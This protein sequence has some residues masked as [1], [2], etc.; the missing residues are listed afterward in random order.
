LEIKKLIF[1][2]SIIEK[3]FNYVL[4]IILLKFWYFIIY[5]ENLIIKINLDFQILLK[6]SIFA[7]FNLIILS[8]DFISVPEETM[9]FSFSNKS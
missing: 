1:I 4:F 3:Q 6:L 5:L 2:V 7:Y 8:K 9:F